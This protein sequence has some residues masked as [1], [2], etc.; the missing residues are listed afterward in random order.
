[1]GFAYKFSFFSDHLEED[2]MLQR[3]QSSTCI[4]FRFL[5]ISMSNT[6]LIQ[7]S[8]FGVYLYSTMLSKRLT[9]IT[10]S[11]PVFSNMLVAT[12]FFF[13]V[14]VVSTA[15][16]TKT[17]LIIFFLRWHHLILYY[18][19]YYYCSYIHIYFIIIMWRVWLWYGSVDKC[20][21]LYRAC[22]LIHSL[23]F[24]IISAHCIMCVDSIFHLMILISKWETSQSLLTP[25]PSVACCFRCRSPFLCV[26]KVFRMLF[27]EFVHLCAYRPIIPST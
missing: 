9:R 26:S 11:F 22:C 8:E 2:C 25:P 4:N 7:L 16:D 1:M 23:D 19:H 13:Y 20:V 17:I 27:S 10:F 5:F 18:S 3:I 24:R 6:K 14:L 21:R 12:Y 15:T